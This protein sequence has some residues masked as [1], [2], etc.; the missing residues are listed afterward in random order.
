MTWTNIIDATHNGSQSHQPYSPQHFNSLVRKEKKNGKHGIGQRPTCW[1]DGPSYITQCPIQA[2]QK[3]NT[4][5]A[6]HISWPRATVHGPL[7]I[8]PK[9]GANHPFE[10]PFEEHVIVL[11]IHSL[12]HS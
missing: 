6:C 9:K 3:R 8:H 1:Y 10:Q 7:I 4:L 2:G 12:D 11:G 5:L